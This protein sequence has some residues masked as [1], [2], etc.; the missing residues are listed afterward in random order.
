MRKAAVMSASPSLQQRQRTPFAR[1]CAPSSSMASTGVLGGEWRERPR[2]RMRQPSLTE[3]AF[4]IAGWAMPMRMTSAMRICAMASSLCAS[5]R[6][7]ATRQPAA[8]KAISMANSADSG[9]PSISTR[10]CGAAS[11]GSADTCR[12]TSSHATAMQGESTASLEWRAKSD[13]LYGFRPSMSLTGLMSDI[14]SAASKWA[15][16]GSWRMM[17]C[18]IG[19]P[20]RLRTSSWTVLSSTSSRKLEV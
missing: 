9:T 17:P 14:K 5:A 16:R 8:R 15:G 12:S 10:A 3:L 4:T 18:T 20:F 1:W 11:V 19:F 6:H 13:T 2:S 7:D